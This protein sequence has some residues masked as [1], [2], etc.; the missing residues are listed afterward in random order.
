MS[1]RRYGLEAKVAEPTRRLS[2]PVVTTFKGRGLLTGTGAPLAG[3]YLGVAGDPA[4]TTLVEESDGLLLLGV[5][6][7]HQF[8]RQRRQ[9]RP[10]PHHP[11]AGP[12]GRHKPSTAIPT[13]R[14]PAWSMRCWR[15]PRRWGARMRHRPRPIQAWSPTRR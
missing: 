14:S 10:A 15:A 12:P 4:V 11:G 9:A 8:R 13:S 2:I 7:E 6:P 3:T 1:R 5:I